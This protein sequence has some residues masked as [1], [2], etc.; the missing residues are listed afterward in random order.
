MRIDGA[1]IA[2]ELM[3]DL[4][5]RVRTCK[6]APSLGVIIAHDSPEIRRFVERKIAFGKAIGVPVH[7]QTLGALERTNERLLQHLLHAT[8]EHDGII[9]QLPLGAHFDQNMLQQLFPLSHDVDVIGDTALEQFKEGTLPFSPPVV[10]AMAEV[11]ERQGITLAGLHV[12]VVGEG[13]LVGAPA[14]MWAKRAGAF[15]VVAN[16]K[17]TDLALKARTADV[18]ILGAGSPCLLTPEMLKEGTVVLD[19]GTSES[20][21]VLRGDADPACEARARVFT[22]TPGGIGP[23]TVAKVFENLLTLSEIKK[24]RVEGA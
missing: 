5:E 4:Q 10:G 11:L 12:L 22:P 23:I 2:R 9:V 13:R 19:A 18:I 21:G 16:R 20:E 24:K 6:R 1:L 15:V 8:H 3:H 14:A 17:T 7:V